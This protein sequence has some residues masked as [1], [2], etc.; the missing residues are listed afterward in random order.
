M[1]CVLAASGCEDLHRH[2]LGTR[3]HQ[4]TIKDTRY[5][6]CSVLMT[7]QKPEMA[8]DA[9]KECEDALGKH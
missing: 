4:F 2:M 7:P 3:V 5:I 1:P 6:H 8:A 9:I